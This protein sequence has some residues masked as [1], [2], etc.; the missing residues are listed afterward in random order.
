LRAHT[1]VDRLDAESILDV[2]SFCGA[3]KETQLRR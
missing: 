2:G 1:R 3:N